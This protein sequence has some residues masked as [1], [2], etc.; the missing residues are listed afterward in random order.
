MVSKSDEPPAVRQAVTSGTNFS[1][2]FSQPGMG[3]YG[4]FFGK[5]FGSSR[6][7]S[8]KGERGINSGK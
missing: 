3:N 5:A 7:L 6:L 1:V 2:Y 8:E 4:H